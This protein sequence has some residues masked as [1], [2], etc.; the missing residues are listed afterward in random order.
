M[1][2]RSEVSKDATIAAV[3]ALSPAEKMQLVQDLWDDLA[4]AL[5]RSRTAPSGRRSATRGA[6]ASGR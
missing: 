6:R 3:F 5:Q 4:H 2:S 1:R